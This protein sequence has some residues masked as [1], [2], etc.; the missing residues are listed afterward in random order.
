[1]GL[2][3]IVILSLVEGITEFV[4]ISSTGHL[5]L[6]GHFLNLPQTEFLKSFNIAVQL[7]AILAVVVLYWRQL[8]L[9]RAVIGRVAAAFLPTAF[10]GLIFYK[11]I[12]T[13]L[14][15]SAAVVIWA[16]FLGGVF[17]ILFERAHREGPEAA[18]R[19]EDISFGKAVLI[20]VFQA[21]A[22]IPGTSR[23]AATIIGGLILGL[24]RRTIVEFSFLLAVPTM[25]AATALDLWKS[26][27]GFADGEW[28][29]IGIGT[30]VSFAVALGAIKFLLHYIQNH[31]FVVFGVYRIILALFAF[32]VL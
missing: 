17:L 3:D 25:A 6:A 18:A 20:G 13:Y 30:A 10:L 2:F 15:G 27:P 23:A 31:T 32:W 11:V 21:A 24:K 19:V 26:A 29:H 7:G 4:P 8:V 5:I 1:M 28:L 16:L 14:L 12:R 9:N 22:M